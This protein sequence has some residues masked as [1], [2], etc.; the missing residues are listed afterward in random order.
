M[1]ARQ[2][3]D[4][5]VVDDAGRLPGARL[6]ATL[7][8]PRAGW[9]AGL[10]AALVGRAAAA[11]GAGRERVEDR[12]DHGAGILVR[13][14]VGRQVDEGEEV[15]ELRSNDTARLERGLALAAKAIAIADTPP[16]TVP[17]IIDTV[18]PNAAEP[19]G[20][21]RVNDQ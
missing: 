21:N 7:R 18:R 10:D 8:A 14:H 2:G 3:G 13:A 15:L 11:L 4:A 19:G 6:R 9:V 16:A 12:V 20:A 5:R 17:L 1:V